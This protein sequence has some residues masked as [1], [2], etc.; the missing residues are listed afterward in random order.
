M[1]E[2]DDVYG[3]EWETYTIDN[4]RNNGE[5]A[6]FAIDY[7][8]YADERKQNVVLNYN[9][10]NTTGAKDFHE[11]FKKD[12]ILTKEEKDSKI[13]YGVGLQGGCTDGTYFYYAFVVV[14]EDSTPLDTRLVCA[15]KDSTG[16][17]E[18]ITRSD[19]LIN[20][21]HHAGDMTYNKST[22]EV[23]IC[24][25]ESGHH[26]EIYTISAE[27]L[28]VGATASD[29]NTHF[30]SCMVTSIDYEEIGN[31][32]VVGI[33]NNPNYFAI[34]DSD[35]NLISTIGQLD[36]QNYDEGWSRQGL[37]CD[38]NYIYSLL[39]FNNTTSN[40]NLITTPRTNEDGKNK[41]RIFK[42]D[43]TLV[44]TLYFLIENS[45]KD[46]QEEY[47]EIE[48]MVVINGDIHIGY[49]C[50]SRKN[51]T[52]YYTDLSK[53]AFYI[54]YC[55]D[56]Y[57]NVYPDDSSNRKA[58]VIRGIA[59]PLYTNRHSAQ[60]YAFAGWMAYRREANAWYYKSA[61][62]STTAWYQEGSQPPGYK[63]YV[64]NENQ[65]VSQTGLI[66]EHVLMCPVWTATNYFYVDFLSNGGSGTMAR[67]TVRHGTATSLTANA[68]SKTVS[69]NMRTF[70]GWQAYWKERNMWYY[71]NTATSATGW[72]QEDCQP[73]GYTK[74]VYTN[75]QTVA[76]TAWKG[77]HIQMHAL[78][79]EFYI[80]YA[81]NTAII[82]QGFE[83]EMQTAW[84]KSGNTN[85]LQNYIQNLTI[86]SSSP[87][88]FEKWRGWYLYR[89]DVD[90]WY[91]ENS[92][93]GYRG[94]H[95]LSG[96]AALGYTRYLKPAERL[97]YLG[98]T[99]RPGEHLI[100]QAK[101]SDWN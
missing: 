55:P 49:F 93:G 47:C 19:G 88:S 4:L 61:D 98:G 9:I 42:W 67:I 83:L 1:A 10:V 39:W 99:A 46:G 53:V 16:T 30:V 3:E 13:N 73:Y 32:Y 78:W 44:K 14:S 57:V 36:Y 65:N 63:K 34:L 96:G 38:E 2:N 62:G 85:L 97:M 35:F 5:V 24:S 17:F 87:R 18:V 11:I 76:R 22:D 45:V 60:G 28:F 56:E 12:V 50:R 51:R 58:F 29:F 84:Y 94:W 23:V 92:D 74:Y 91:F 95:T 20:K 48:N 6:T 69:G 90:L 7:D 43:G 100:L 41:L 26:Q 79:D 27:K 72:Y 25:S 75:G 71:E 68:F 8:S 15:Q 21:I 86:D 37:Y 70:Q 80:Y 77:G 101:W 82:N 89:R 81:A 54:Q 59:T 64:Y 40:G 31:Q 52:F 66:G 33:T